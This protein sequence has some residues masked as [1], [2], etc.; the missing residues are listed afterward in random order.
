[1]RVVFKYLRV[2]TMQNPSNETFLL[3]ILLRGVGKS[4]VKPGTA[5]YSA[6][7]VHHA[8]HFR[9]AGAARISNIILLGGGVAEGD[10]GDIRGDMGGD[11]EVFKNKL[12][13]T[14]SIFIRKTQKFHLKNN[15]PHS[16]FLRLKSFSKVLP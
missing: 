10:I 16:T 14:F 1:M 12:S 11:M 8:P 7:K 5:R 4:Q 2:V 13:K 3:K 15:S 9:K 6:E